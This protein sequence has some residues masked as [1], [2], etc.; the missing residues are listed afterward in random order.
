[1]LQDRAEPA[2][3][4]ESATRRPALSVIIPVYNSAED[5]K[6]CLAALD[7]S[8]F[9]DFEVLVV[10][11]GS[12]EPIEPIVRSHGFGYVRID[13]PGGPARA[14]NYGA[15]L[16]SGSHLVFID[17]DVCVHADT[18]S[19]FAEAFSSD[20]TI[21]AVIGSYDDAPAKPNFLSQY[22]NLF[23]HYVHQN[24]SGDISTFWTGC[25][26]IR[27]DLFISFGGFDERRY[28]RPAIE[29]IELGTWMTAAGHRIVLD[30]SIKAKHLKKWTLYSLL[31]TDIFDRGVPWTRLMLR[32]GVIVDTLNVKPVQRLSVVMVYLALLL[33]VAS[34]WW[35]AALLASAALAVAVTA[36]NI[37][38]YRYFASR[39]GWW[40]AA[41]VMP[42]HWL[43][44]VYCGFSVAWGT[45]L[46]H[47]DRDS[48]A[49][50][51]PKLLKPISAPQ[52]SDRTGR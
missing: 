46:H 36:L 30:K 1:M 39:S 42:M 9:D 25:G 21:D 11:D 13:G 32:S 16:V 43:Y 35:P 7:G 22:K 3:A 51:S 6:L 14:R 45:L 52:Q 40:F 10:D 28:R 26:A 41:R 8:L 47:L 31:K 49:G 17:A 19:R 33:V 29:D 23:H 5:L 2:P 50:P 27:R 48:E 18:L 20:P 12:T 34:V 38:F 15:G 44:F 4:G 37:D 24:C